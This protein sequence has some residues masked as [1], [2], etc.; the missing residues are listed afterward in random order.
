MAH[1]LGG[2]LQVRI[3]RHH[4]ALQAVVNA[5][6]M[7]DDLDAVYLGHPQINQRNLTRFVLGAFDGLV[8]VGEHPRTIP[9]FFQHQADHVT[10]ARIVIDHQNFDMVLNGHHS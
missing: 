3:C 1:Q 2:R 10:D 9:V 8:G 6:E 5:L 4:E 7:L